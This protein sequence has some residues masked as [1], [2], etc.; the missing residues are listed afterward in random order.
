[1]DFR[2]WYA[3][4]TGSSIM[5]LQSFNMEFTDL[6]RFSRTTAEEKR[7]HFTFPRSIGIGD[8]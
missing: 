1:M 4:V 7:G 5:V 8:Q 2:A 6:K 3:D